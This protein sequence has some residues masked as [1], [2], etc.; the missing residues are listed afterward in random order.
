VAVSAMDVLI[1]GC[2]ATREII[3][4]KLRYLAIPTSEARAIQAGAAD[5]YGKAAETRI[6]DGDGLPCRHCLKMIA[7]GEPYLV[8]AYRPFSSIQ[9]YAETGPIFLHAQPCE[10]ASSE[11]A[12]DMLISPDYIVRGYGAD[13]RIVYGTGGVVQTSDIESRSIE[14]LAR[15]DVAFIHV[16]SARNN[17]YQC[18][19]ESA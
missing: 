9:P 2:S 1:P 14:L 6:S 13:E 4:T 19:I 5:A 7:A 3:M 15:D 17:C 12:P 10:A 18:R 16:R 8:L 11:R